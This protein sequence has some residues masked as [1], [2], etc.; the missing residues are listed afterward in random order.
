MLATELGEGANVGSFNLAFPVP[1][2]R[3]VLALVARVGG[4]AALAPT[5][6]GHEVAP[7]NRLA[8][9]A[10]LAAML[11]PILPAAS[12]M[13]TTARHDAFSEV[14]TELIVGLAFGFAFRAVQTAML[15]ATQLIEQQ[16]GLLFLS[17]VSDDAGASP[18]GSLYQLTAGAIFFGLGGHRLVIGSLVDLSADV[19][20]SRWDTLDVLDGLVTLLGQACWMGVR[21]AAPIALVLMTTSLA[22]G[23]LSRVLP[24]FAGPAVAQP[25]QVALGL[26][27]VLL[28]IAVAGPTLAD[29]L[30]RIA[31][32]LPAKLAG[33]AG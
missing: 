8:L 17:E 15:L 10:V 14:V 25:I 30:A 31:H 23:M 3:D 33:D 18:L 32:L 19:V 1:A 5:L 21:T 20:G 24:Q 9:A 6:T 16:L 28:S 13:T 12:P 29:G 22:V 11:M 26:L 27:L 2:L 7:R 4:F